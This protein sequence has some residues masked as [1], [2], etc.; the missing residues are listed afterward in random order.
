MGFQ[1][2]NLG[3]SVSPNFYFFVVEIDDIYGIYGKEMK[4]YV[5]QT[6]YKTV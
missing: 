6:L 1:S 3:L 4:T 2:D 5:H